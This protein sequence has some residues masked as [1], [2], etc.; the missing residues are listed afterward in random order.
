MS[1]AVA[2]RAHN[3]KLVD[4]VGKRA[5]VPANDRV[6]V[7]FLTETDRPGKARFEVAAASGDAADAADVELP[8][9]TPATTEAFATY[10]VIDQGAIAQPISMPTGVFHSVRRPRDDD[11]LDC[12]PGAH[13][14]RALPRP[15]PL[16]CNEQLSSRMLAIASLRDVLTAFD[17]KDLPP[18]AELEASVAADLD[19]LRAARSGTVAGRFWWGEEWPFVSIHV[20]HALARADAKG[21][22]LTRG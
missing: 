8:V 13:R 14:R 6:E 22:R 9:W 3:A 11:V 4:A 15:L 19:K 2:A 12:A 21:Y 5:V 18:P 7:R 10:G 20:A 1:V 16:E 17:S